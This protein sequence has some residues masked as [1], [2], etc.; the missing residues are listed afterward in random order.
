[1]DAKDARRLQTSEL[2]TPFLKM[3]SLLEQRDL[4]CPQELRT[5]LRLR[6]PLARP[7][8]R[9][10]ISMGSALFSLN[11]LLVGDLRCAAQMMLSRHHARYDQISQWNL[12]Q[13]P[14]N[15]SLVIQRSEHR[16]PRSLQMRSSRMWSKLGEHQFR[17]ERL[18]LRRVRRAHSLGRALRVWQENPPADDEEAM[19]LRTTLLTIAGVAV[20][21]LVLL[22]AVIFGLRLIN[23]GAGPDD[24]VKV[25]PITSLTLA[26]AI[27]IAE[28]LGLRIK[29]SERV[30]SESLPVDTIL[31]QSPDPSTLVPLNSVIEVRVVA[32]SGLAVVPDLLGTTEEEATTRLRAANL[33]LGQVISAWSP[34]A[35]LGSVLQQNPRAGLQ[36]ANGSRVDLVV[37]L[38][39]EPSPGVSASPSGV[40]D[41]AVPVLR[42][43]AVGEASLMLEAVGLT[44][45]PASAALDV[46]EIVDVI[47][48]AAGVLVPS[49]SVVTIVA[50]SPF[51][52]PLA[53]CP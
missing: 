49:G 41:T 30:T 8:Q 44:L 45:D 17:R 36:V 35:P 11:C 12:S 43:V 24:N 7:L 34:D 1:L 39:P 15:C 38:G 26:E 14:C 37:S 31:S 50:T 32:G 40:A 46:T 4:Q 10:Q 25:P 21:V 20:T 19:P 13:S 16:A 23:A 28:Q 6:L 51:G 47:S 5:M 22:A 33:R 2:H 18:A 53:G 52:T 9:H 29:V 48:P 42:C 3:V 27:P